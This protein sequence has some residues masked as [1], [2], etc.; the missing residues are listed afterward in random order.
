MFLARNDFRVAIYF[1]LFRFL[2]A[3][4]CKI[5]RVRFFGD[6]P[7]GGMLM[8]SLIEFGKRIVFCV[9]LLPAFASCLSGWDWGGSK[10]VNLSKAVW[11]TA[12]K[13][14][15]AIDKGGVPNAPPG[16][17]GVP[18]ITNN[19]FANAP[20]T[21]VSVQSLGGTI[22]PTGTSIVND[23]DGDGILNV[24]ETTTNIWLADYPE[25]QTIVKTP[26]TMKITIEQTSSQE[27]DEIVSDVIG[28]DME[29]TL[30]EGSEKVHQNEVNERTVQFQDSFSNEVATS[31]DVALGVNASGFGVSA[32][33]N[34][35][36]SWSNKYANSGTV[37]KWATK[38][39]KNDIDR[40]ASSIKFDSSSKKARKY[41]S[42][43]STKINSGIKIGSNAGYVRAALT[44]QNLSVNMPVK[45]R[46]ILC[47]LMF[48]DGAGNLSPVQ[49]F[50]LRN[51]DYSIFEVSIYGG[52]EFGPYVIELPGLNTAEIENAIL[53]GYTPKIFIVDYEMSHVADSNYRSVLLNFSGDNLKII[54]E[55]SKG[56][57]GL[58]KAYGPNIRKKYRVTAF[59][60]NNSSNPCSPSA[61]TASTLSPG[62][63]LRK[64][65]ERISCSGVE[66]AFEDYVFDLSEQLPALGEARL[67]I[68]GIKSFDGIPTRIPCEYKTFT[69]S[70]SV[71]RTAC[72]QKPVSQWT[73]DEKK[74]AGIWAIYS[75]GRFNSPTQY[76]TDGSNIR[77]F[78]P[79][80]FKYAP[81]V[82]G[83]DSIIWAGD[84]YDLVYI[85]LKDL[86]IKE[87]TPSYPTTPVVSDIEFKMNTSWDLSKVGPSPYEPDVKSKYLGEVG[88]DEKV[89]L[90]ITLD[91]TQYL[92]PNFGT[93]ES[94]GTF[95]F[96]SNF[97]YNKTTSTLRFQDYQV[98]DFE[99]SLGF[100]G[101]RT[102]WVHIIKDVPTG[103]PATKIR[104]CG[105]DNSG[106]VNQTFRICLRMPATIPNLTLDDDGSA[107]VKLYIRP[108]LNSAYRRTIWPLHYSQVK[109]MRGELDVPGKIADT[110][111]YLTGVY[112]NIETGDSFY[113][114][115]DT[116]SYTVDT[117]TPLEKLG[118]YKIT[119]TSGLRYDFQKTTEATIPG[120]LTS[121][122]VRLSVDNTFITE[123][124]NQVNAAP[125]SNYALPQY[126][127][128][129]TG[130]A[131]LACSGTNQFNPYGCL[132]FYPD[133]QAINWMGNYNN[134]SAFWN[135]WADAGSF[136][137]FVPDGK[138]EL[139]TGSGRSYKIGTISSDY[140]LS[141][142]GSAVPLSKP[143]MVV[144]GD[145]AFIV[146]RRDT[147]LQGKFI[148]VSTGESL[149]PQFVINPSNAMSTAATFDVKVSNGIAVI[150]W[151]NTNLIFMA[152]R[153]MQTYQAIGA[154]T[155]VMANVPNN[156]PFSLALGSNAV[157]L[158]V[159][160]DAWAIN[161]LDSLKGL[162]G[163]RFQIDKANNS[164]L[165]LGPS[166][167]IEQVTNTL[168]GLYEGRVDANGSRAVIVYARNF[169]ANLVSPA[170]YSVST[171][172]ID[173]NTGST[174]VT[175]SLLSVTGA[176]LGVG[177][178]KVKC[179]T[180]RCLIAFRNHANTLLGRTVNVPSP[181]L[182]LPNAG[183]LTLGSAVTSFNLSSDDAS[184]LVSYASGTGIY[185]RGVNLAD[186]N[187]IT[188]TPLT[189]GNTVAGSV[190]T[191]G[192]SLIVGN[193]V[194]TLWEHLEGGKST[195]RGRQSTLS[196]FLLKGT[197]EFFVSTAN[198]GSQVGPSGAGINGTGFAVWLSNDTTP[199]QQVIRSYNLDLVNPGALRYGLNNFFIS[200]LIER[201]YSI[202][203]KIVF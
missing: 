142:A 157:A 170:S 86:L 165:A 49:S 12:E 30:N 186:G 21:K 195:I 146:W 74:T 3:C 72:V 65:L 102:D 48:E 110:T 145:T 59:D 1:R 55:N 118:D 69:G 27:S 119:L 36:A 202:K 152:A 141:D 150:A 178:M 83:V 93:A 135:S 85:S 7:F 140:I 84:Y 33:F 82:K 5:A 76:W 47:T 114:K 124:N 199:A 104:N 57:T 158:V 136:Y 197:S 9:L 169:Y 183:N 35:S 68:K 116:L 58:I 46:N 185:L 156:V 56:R 111:I 14:P 125:A 44:I 139:T 54:E 128:F 60:T 95:T 120:T 64:A 88:L 188:T 23:F 106:Y 4:K 52:S 11:L 91:K 98:L 45:L 143:V 181:S 90:A 173:L 176:N 63:T 19:L 191:P 137:S 50:R 126:L 20:G 149:A 133:Y 77:I 71:S 108:A 174:V 203:A 166:F 147:F 180:D 148:K 115:G 167:T 87:V 15:L 161:L 129:L 168:A 127:P 107:S 151:G 159:W 131:P 189:L 79:G 29:S 171:K 138:F 163:R 134:G 100:G 17:I 182:L 40:E 24:N 194:I 103:A 155:P 97:S 187:N 94:G 37:T 13:V 175:N 200:P 28:N 89:T 153:D 172:V 109:K 99:V 61:A 62:V 34:S 18:V 67:H 179:A 112:G 66:V 198:Q 80:N 16:S 154:V 6:R 193:T 92:N 32:G 184:G 53:S 26:I 105:I 123:W 42:D 25:I 177:N 70:D 192:G 113:L 132:G 96:N 75:N 162:F 130:A 121:P 8:K 81:M 160:N 39:F 31:A 73:E 201:D 51:D 38:P 117:I 190:K 10:D 196:P 164:I 78:D 43:K 22:D 41:R 122:D 101:T 144:E 2:S